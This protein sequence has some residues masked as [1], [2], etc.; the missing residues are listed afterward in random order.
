MGTLSQEWLRS[1]RHTY[2]PE[3]E[4]FEL[5]MTTLRSERPL[6]FRPFLKPTRMGAAAP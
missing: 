4:S 1:W 5:M 6:E 3:K 2:R